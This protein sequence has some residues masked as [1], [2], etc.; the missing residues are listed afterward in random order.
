M[1]LKLLLD[2]LRVEEV[3]KRVCDAGVLLVN[4]QRRVFPS[5]VSCQYSFR[6][7]EQIGLTQTG[8]D[9]FYVDQPVLYN[10]QRGIFLARLR[11][12]VLIICALSAAAAS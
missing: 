7:A 10:K 2:V 3:A 9:V 6:A 12:V 4:F 11:R 8:S 1:L 5:N